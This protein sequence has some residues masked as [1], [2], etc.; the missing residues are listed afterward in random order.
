MEISFR[1]E[2]VAIWKGLAGIKGRPTERHQ[3]RH[4]LAGVFLDDGGI[5]RATFPDGTSNT[6]VSRRTHEVGI[7]LAIG[8]DRGQVLRMVLG[9]GMSLA[10]L[11][12]V[13]GIVG[14]VALTRLMTSV[15]DEVTPADPWTYVAVATGLLVVAALASA[16]PA[17]RAARVDPVTA[18]RI[19]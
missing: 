8:A 16:I 3:H 18:L 2:R 13:A 19:E 14:A 17:L 6:R 11:G 9:Q 4:D 12:L 1:N 15:L 7:R 5:S 10:A